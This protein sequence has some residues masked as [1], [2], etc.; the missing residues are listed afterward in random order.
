[1]HCV[2]LNCQCGAGSWRMHRSVEVIG[3]HKADQEVKILLALFLE[4]QASAGLEN[5]FGMMHR[6]NVDCEVKP[7]W[8]LPCHPD[9]KALPARN[10]VL[11]QLYAPAF[12]EVNGKL[13]QTKTLTPWDECHAIMDR[14]VIPW[15]NKKGLKCVRGLPCDQSPHYVPF[16]IWRVGPV[17]EPGNYLIVCALAFRGQTYYEL[18]E[19]ESNFTIDGPTRL[20][21]RVK[22]EDLFRLPQ[23][24]RTTWAQHL[25]PFEG[26]QPLVGDGYDIIILGPPLADEVRTSGKI[27]I[28]S[29]PLQP[30]HGPRHRAD[31]FITSG[32][33]FS[34][35]AKYA[36]EVGIESAIGSLALAAGAS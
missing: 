3:Y 7:A 31:R 4:N 21:A 5:Y 17:T 8:P 29:A 26:A 18:V 11:Q 34:M 14:P 25:K 12:N 16:T 19:R 15:A 2:L 13:F 30:A 10:R 24:E 23:N 22:Y 1:M 35:V 27:G 33:T 20:L 32:R 6:G 36:H 9:E 28:L